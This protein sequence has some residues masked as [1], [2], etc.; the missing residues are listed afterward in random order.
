MS[1]YSSICTGVQ[2]QLFVWRLEGEAVTGPEL[3]LGD[4]GRHGS[5]VGGGRAV[6]LD[7]RLTTV[8]P[9]LPFLPC[10]GWQRACRGWSCTPGE[11]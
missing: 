11:A 9:S 8:S 2:K 1:S 5:S 7:V 10:A 3:L 4:E 6:M